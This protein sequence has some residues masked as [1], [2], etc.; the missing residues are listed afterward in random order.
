MSITM[1]SNR[2][3]LKTS[4]HPK[5]FEGGEIYLYIIIFLKNQAKFNFIL[6]KHRLTICQQEELENRRIAAR[7]PRQSGAGWRLFTGS[8]PPLPLAEEPR[9]FRRS[10]SIS[11]QAYL[12]AILRPRNPSFK[13]GLTVYRRVRGV[14]VN[15][16]VK[17]QKRILVA[18]RESE[19]VTLERRPATVDNLTEGKTGRG[20]PVRLP[21]FGFS[22]NRPSAGEFAP[23]LYNLPSAC[24]LTFFGHELIRDNVT[25][26]DWAFISLFLYTAYPPTP[27]LS[28]YCS[29]L[30][31]TLFLHL[32]NSSAIPSTWHCIF[33]LLFQPLSVSIVLS[34]ICTPLL[35]T[36]TSTI[37]SRG[38][39]F[40][41]LAKT[42]PRWKKLH[43]SDWVF[44]GGSL[45]RGDRLVF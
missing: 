33:S 32:Y 34:R 44:H 13:S 16:K 45:L 7:K 31:Y 1:S 4:K 29:L 8:N 23:L 25:L 18:G 5:T 26:S 40:C 14:Y 28:I 39:P 10:F 27:F 2:V 43:I 20:R 24:R 37:A 41:T 30:V 3:L 15:P 6:K 12:R 17:P 35:F 42:I 22:F 36:K 21:L 38:Q 19:H 11:N 9:Q